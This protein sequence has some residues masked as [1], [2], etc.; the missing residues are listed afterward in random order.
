[1]VG[2]ALIT[3]GLVPL[4]ASAAAGAD[5]VAPTAGLVAEYL[6]DQTSGSSIPNRVSGAPAATVVNGTDAQ[7]TGSSLVF[8][9][10]AKTSP[11]AN[12][13]RLP[14]NVLSGKTSATVT[15]ETKLDPTMKNN[16][17]FLW[18]IGSDSTTQYY[19]ASVR[20]NARTA[21]TA[22]GSGGE[23]NA[24][25]GSALAANRWYSL[26]SV[27]DGAAGRITFY[28]DGEQVASA[29]TA[30]TPASITNQ[31]LNA[32]GRAPYPDPMYKGEVSSFRVYDRALTA[33]EVGDV[34]VADAALHAAS[35]QQAA[36]TVVDGVAALTI[37]ESPTTLPTYGGR[38]AW[39]SSDPAIVVGEDGVSVTA[40]QP[41]AGSPALQTTLTAT[42][43]VRGAAATRQVPVTVRPAAAPTDAFG[44]AM[45]HF[46]ENSAGYAEKIYLDVS[47]GDNPEQ[48]DPLNG[49][50]PILAS[51]LG[52]TGIRDPYLTYNPETQTY[53]I[54]ATDLRVFGGDRGVSG[55]M[56]WCHWSSKG[57][58]KLN[59]WESKDLV[60]WSDLRQFDV[61][62]S[63][64][65]K[66]AEL[67]M[68]WAP[69]ATWV[70]DYYGP[71]QGGFVLYWSSNVYSNPQHTGGTYSRILWGATP[72]FTQ[73]TY[74]YG[75]VFIDAGGNTI[76]TT[77]TQHEG[78]TYRVTK[79][80]SAGKGLYLESTPDA[81]WWKPSATWTQ[82]QTRIGAQWTGGDAGG[83]E[84]PAIFQRH[85][86]DRWYL[87]VDVIPT[88]GYR[89]MQTTDLDAGF[90]QLIS[91]SFYMAPSTK[92]GGIVGLTK[93][94]YDAIREADAATAV[95][96]DLGAVEVEADASEPDVRA[97]L[98][99]ETDV[100]L[101]YGRGTASQPVDWDL[102]DVD[103]SSAGTYEVTGTVR[104]IGAN[105][106]QWVGTGGS[107]AWNA[108]GKEL[109]SSTA[110]TV[111]ADV[112]V[113][114]PVLPVTV[115]ADTR[116]VAGKVVVTARTTNDGTAPVALSVTT[117]YGSKSFASVQPGKSVSAAF[118]TRAASIGT[119]TVTVT[120]SAGGDSA[121]ASASYPAAT[122]G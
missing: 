109:Y 100:V 49:G 63:D 47:R 3:G 45:V 97:A 14:D 16:W 43:T 30:L 76:D 93:S 24:R 15:I 119:G 75:G 99:A 37:D 59:V 48:W 103:T 31:T 60:S 73:A 40:E 102:S 38:V 104:T 22:S 70:P 50:K 116:C 18:N 52:T 34:S 13:V 54:I 120:V 32:I 12:W 86:E 26:T 17:N 71:G 51:D 66:V 72:D 105:L 81:E 36:Q 111:T 69:E 9:G 77:I 46:I 83:V 55:C 82:L 114:A 79:D 4:G 11:T 10:G 85:D 110:I 101:A 118:T 78:K 56:E 5:A 117:P 27:I 106:N 115:A 29:A 20:D 121:E 21:I 84:G 122:C 90:T 64:G 23:A 8:A 44:Y 19:F 113:A 65:A 61:A 98:P 58:T 42:A 25:S 107:T 62:L 95:T 6:F 91:S 92:H 80:N 1:M 7:W 28:V 88:T 35:H 57:S 74:D 108:P 2:A 112:V 94:Q 87:Y 39:T 89:P 68:A 33:A 41:A 96:A 53:Y 67:G